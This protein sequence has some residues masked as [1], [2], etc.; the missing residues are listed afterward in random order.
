MRIAHSPPPAHV[1]WKPTT[2]PNA[3]DGKE[4]PEQ[5]EPPENQANKHA[6]VIRK[7]ASERM[8]G[9]CPRE[10]ASRHRPQFRD[11]KPPHTKWPDRH[12]AR[13]DDFSGWKLMDSQPLEINHHDEK[14]GWH[15]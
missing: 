6:Q 3:R 9:V 1:K 10:Q 13:D 14:S 12:E 2:V 4:Q 5:G 11:G 8:Y 7:V 15:T